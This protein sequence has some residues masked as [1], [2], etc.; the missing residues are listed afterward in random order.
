MEPGTRIVTLQPQ[1]N[2][3][4]VSDNPQMAT[5]EEAF[6]E[7]SNLFGKKARA[8]RSKRKASRRE[9]RAKKRTARR[10]ARNANKAERVAMRDERRRNKSETRQQRRNDRKQNRQDMRL[11][12]RRSRQEQRANMRAERQARRMQKRMERQAQKQARKDL[13]A[14]REAERE[15]EA[16][17]A[18]QEID[19][20]A[21][22]DEPQGDDGYDDGGYDSYDEGYGEYDTAGGGSYDDYD[23]SD[24]YGDASGYNPYADTQALPPSSGPAYGEYDTGGGGSYDDYGDTSGGNWWE[25]DDFYSGGSDDFSYDDDYGY[26]DGS[27][28]DSGYEDYGNDYGW[29]GFDGTGDNSDRQFVEEMAQG[30]GA[31]EY[32][33]GGGGSYYSEMAGLEDCCNKIEWNEELQSNFVDDPEFSGF[34]GKGRD[35]DQNESNARLCELKENVRQWVNFEGDDE[36]MSA[37]GTYKKI[38][39]TRRIMGR[40]KAVSMAKRKARAKRPSMRGK[41]K[42]RM[43]ARMKA[44]AAGGAMS[45]RPMMAKN[46]MVAKRRAVRKARRKASRGGLRVAGAN[47]QVGPMMGKRIAQG[48]ATKVEM[49]LTP[50]I[51]PQRIEVPASSFTGDGSK[52]TTFPWKEIGIGLG[53]GVAGV[54]LV[55]QLS[56]K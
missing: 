51:S 39:S 16:M 2:M 26:D 27:Y 7:Y 48:K 28:D 18:Q 30:E 52:T 29:G 25:E 8:R 41:V 38:P 5:F 33:T 6:G 40:M 24:P 15:R 11:E 22:T 10:E 45:K 1:G 53:V 37:D 54:I 36:F 50:K 12:R 32:Y 44:R 21:Y 19:E 9:D 56:K 35:T 46:P 47:A 3:S 43:K 55:K 17:L 13:K 14:S 34:S 49:G 42:A 4:V 20:M 31:G 23:P